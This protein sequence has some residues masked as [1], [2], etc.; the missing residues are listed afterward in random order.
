MRSDGEVG[1]AARDPVD[2]ARTARAAQHLRLGPRAASAA[3]SGDL[4]HP[5]ASC[6]GAEG[7]LDDPRRRSRPPATSLCTASTPAASSIASSRVE[8]EAADRRRAALVGE[9]G[10]E[11]HASSS[12]LPWTSVTSAP[13]A[14]VAGAEVQRRTVDPDLGLHEP[15]PVAQEGEVALVP[16]LHDGIRRPVA[17]RPRRSARARP[18]SATRCSASVVVLVGLRADGS[19]AGPSGRPRR[20][21]TRREARPRRSTPRSPTP[22]R[23]TPC[24]R[25]PGPSVDG[26]LRAEVEHRPSRYCSV[27]ARPVRPRARAVE[28]ADQRAQPARCPPRCPAAAGRG[29]ARQRGCRRPSEHRACARVRVRASHRTRR[30]AV[31]SHAIGVRRAA[32]CDAGRPST[33]QAAGSPAGSAAPPSPARAA[34]ASSVSTLVDVP[35]SSAALARVSDCSGRTRTSR[36]RRRRSPQPDRRAAR[37][38][39]TPSRPWRR[40]RADAVAQRHAVPVGDRPASTLRSRSR[41]PPARVAAGSGAGTAR[42][43]AA[44]AALR[45]RRRRWSLRSTEGAATGCRDRPRDAAASPPRSG[46][47]R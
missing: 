45:R 22:C 38:V 11:L 1:R 44:D 29:P 19:C 8:V 21:P 42:R 7:V 43:R 39:P 33:A 17:R 37:R 6:A 15:G 23:R 41:L 13:A 3:A 9:V 20:T 14:L 31:R 46:L 28:V 4:A 5:G 27:G 18:R 34:R 25:S 36:A 40:R 30:A 10:A 24:A 2:R 16:L 32:R 26:D 35:R 47:Q 12:S